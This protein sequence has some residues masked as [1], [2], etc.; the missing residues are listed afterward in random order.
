MNFIK[1]KEMESGPETGKETTTE[2]ENAVTSVIEGA[3]EGAV[4]GATKAVKKP[5]TMYEISSW[6]DEHLNL[7]DD[8]LRGIYAYG[9][10][11]PSSIQKKAI[12]PFIYGINNKQRD[13]IAQAQSGTGK[14]G[15]FAAGALQML[16][17]K[18]K[19]P[20][21]LILA[22]THELA[23]QI[24][25]VIDQLSNYMDVKSLLLVGGVSIDENR[26]ELNNNNPQVIVGT[27]GRVQDMI[28][29]GYL[30]TGDM[31][32]LILDEADEMLSTG[33]KEQMGKILQQMPESIKIGLFSATLSE[34]LL[35]VSKTF[36]INPIKILVKNKELT[37]QG[38]A[39]Y[40]VNLND[41]SGKYDTLKDIFSTLTLSQS[42]IYCNSTRRVD[43]LEEAMLEDNFPVKKI[44]GKMSSDER[45]RTNKEFK[46]GSC[47]VLITSDL[48]ARGIDVQQVSMVIN[49]DIPK[50]EHTYL[51]R[52]GRS[53]RWGRKGIAI[54]FQTKYDEGKL[55]QFEEYYNTQIEEM[56]SN[57][58]DHLNV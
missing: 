13:I 53:G 7:K 19:V 43:D 30:Q 6:E 32:L 56:P 18:K 9:F 54:N 22:P 1:E 24:K 45:R 44:H 28:R 38:I 4:E 3:V 46:S 33:F 41:D 17:E 50:S 48:F 2:V 5:K 51:H 20:Q 16:D 55:K 39:Q 35:E 36:M 29:R 23:R 42:I 11:Q 49:F 58:A 8:L 15:C 27:P 25:F 14:T 34:E 10:E 12:Y 40:Y 52:I 57:Y 26:K 31:R 47:R 37:L 21:V